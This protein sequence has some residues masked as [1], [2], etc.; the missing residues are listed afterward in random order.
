MSEET[1]LCDGC[2]QPATPEHLARRFKRLELTTRYRP[3]HIQTVFLAIASPAKDE[4]FLYWGGDGGFQGEAGALL[5]TAGIQTASKTPD[6]VLAEFQKQG[7]LLAHVLECPAE[8]G[9][10]VNAL[11]ESRIRAV[12]TRLKK[13]LKPKHVALISPGLSQHARQFHEA[14]LDAEIRTQSLSEA[15]QGV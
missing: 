9:A 7:L 5:K 13:S 14:G 11:I 8:P 10:D 12:L 15:A 6:A 3:V 1:L 2:G 4:D